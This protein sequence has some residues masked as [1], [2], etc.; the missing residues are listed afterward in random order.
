MKLQDKANEDADNKYNA[1]V[2]KAAEDMKAKDEA[3]KESTGLNAA[4]ADLNKKT[5][6]QK[7][8]ETE[9]EKKQEQ[10]VTDQKAQAEAEKEVETQKENVKKAEDN[11]ADAE[12]KA[13]TALDNY[14][15]H[16]REED[17]IVTETPEPSPKPTEP[18]KPTPT[19]EGAEEKK[20]EVDESAAIIY[21]S[22]TDTYS[23]IA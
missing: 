1:S 15:N 4:E 20:E 16:A 10:L 3:L 18:A 6:E 11:L 19:P 21:D 9:L 13:D 17:K 8:A 12:K 22:A 2:E 5:E 23:I 14:N 7:V